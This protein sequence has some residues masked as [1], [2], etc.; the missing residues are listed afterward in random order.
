MTRYGW[1][2]Y[3]SDPFSCN[4]YDR[5]MQRFDPG[6]GFNGGSYTMQPMYTPVVN[7]NTEFPQLGSTHAPQ[8]SAEHQPRP[9]PQHMPGSWAAQS[10]PAGMGYGHPEPMMSP[11]NPSQVGAHSSSTMYLHSS[12]YP[13]QHPGMPFIHHEH[14]HHPF[15][16]VW[17]LLK[18]PICEVKS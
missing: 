18:Y 2:M 6:F 1:S 9:L 15:P 5:Y 14:I 8:R 11:F 13:C 4:L 16:Q 7:Y 3:K 12:P 10:T 17:Q